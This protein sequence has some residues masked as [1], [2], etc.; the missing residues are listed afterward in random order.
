MAASEAVRKQMRI[1]LFCIDPS[2]QLKLAWQR[3][4][5]AIL[6]SA[7]LTPGGYFQTVLGC[8]AQ[9]GMLNLPSPFPPSNLAVFAADRISTLFKERLDSCEAVTA[10][11]ADLVGQRTGHYMLYFPSYQYMY[12]VYELFGKACLDV[13]TLVQTP[14]MGEEARMAFLCRFKEEVSR[15]LVG[16][17]VM[18][19]I[20]G[21]GIDLKGE[22][23]TGAVIVGVGLPGISLERDLIRDYYNRIRKCG[24]EFAYQYPGI[25]RVLQAAGRVI[26]SEKDQGMVLLIDRRYSH[27]RYRTLLPQHWQLQVVGD[28]AEFKQQIRDFWNGLG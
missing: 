15:T 26:R 13:E 7:T 11:I 25:N 9:A 20:F 21:E 12:L 23:L 8:H 5:S 6:F 19:G 18:G 28:G 3:C 24:F 16:F 10:I 1:R 22:R 27:Q 14:D 17:A 4:R 2:H